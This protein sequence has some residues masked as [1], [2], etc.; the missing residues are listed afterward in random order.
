[1]VMFSGDGPVLPGAENRTA[2]RLE[3]QLRY[4]QE[5]SPGSGRHHTLTRGESWDPQQTALIVC[6]MWDLHHCHR[7]VLRETEFAPRLNALLQEVRRQGVTIIHAP[8]DCMGYYAEHP[9]RR[10]AV[11]TPRAAQLPPQIGEWC[12][13]IPAEEQ[14]IYPIDQ[15]AGGEDDDPDEHAQWA[16]ELTAKGLNPRRPWTHQ[17]PL[18]EIDPERDYISDRGEE[19][20]S[21]LEQ[22]GIRNVILT[23]VHTNM[24]VLGRPFGL[25]QMAK[26]GKN[27]VLMRD[28]TDTMYDPR[29]WPY[30]SHFTGTDLIVAHIEK[31]VCPT[32]TSDQFL[33]GS[34]FRFS[35][36]TRPHVAILMAEDEYE[37]EQTL[38]QYALEHLGKEFRV[39]YVFG[40]DADR[41]DIPGLEVLEEADV[42]VVSVRRRPLRPEQLERIRAFVKSGKPVVGIRTASHAFCLRNQPPPEGLADW[43]G[44]DAEVFGGNY[45]NHHGNQLHSLVAWADGVSEHPVLTGVPREF[46]QGGSLYKTSPLKPGTTVLLMGRL[47]DGS[48]PPEPVA[49]TFTRADGGKSFYT[50][51]G[52]KQDF[53]GEALPRLLTNAIRWAVGK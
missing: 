12:R 33:G 35:E 21:I 24:C 11:E 50:S 5:T 48:A 46:P 32:I 34:P 6:D 52:H 41:G 42:L 7:A 44:W 22:R 18:L 26:N 49:W 37:T 36:D 8:S 15:S 38:P 43:V 39:S 16:A 23:G 3:L 2:G 28:L 53:A 10:R 29:A 20:W 40:S 9:A 45:T 19:V 17:T 51:L 25:R 47:T 13:Q 4:R 30:V 1:M 14:G 31:Y 27:V